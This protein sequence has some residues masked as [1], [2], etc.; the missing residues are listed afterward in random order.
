LTLSKARLVEGT[1]DLATRGLTDG[2]FSLFNEPG[3]ADQLNDPQQV[4]NARDLR[5]L[6]VEW[7]AG[8][9]PAGAQA[10]APDRAALLERLQ[11]EGYFTPAPTPPEGPGGPQ[12]PPPPAGG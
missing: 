10:V 9:A 11:G 6:L 12:P 1:P 4:Q 7:R 5:G 3:P 2:D 8:L